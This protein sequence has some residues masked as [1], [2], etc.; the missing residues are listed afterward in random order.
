MEEFFQQGDEEKR[1]GVEVSP[2]CDREKSTVFSTQVLR[3]SCL[4]VYNNNIIIIICIY[5]T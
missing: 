2:M 5:F 3:M 1:R 4:F